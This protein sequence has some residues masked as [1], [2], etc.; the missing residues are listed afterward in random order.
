MG[1]KVISVPEAAVTGLGAGIKTVGVATVDAGKEGV[2]M[3][4]AASAS[5]SA[6]MSLSLPVLVPV[7]MSLS[8][9]ASGSVPCGFYSTELSAVVT[10]GAVSLPASI[11][12]KLSQ[13]RGDKEKDKDKEKEREKL[14]S[15]SR[16]RFINF[17]SRND[18]SK[19]CPR[20][21][22]EITLTATLTLTPPL[23]LVLLFAANLDR[24][25][26]MSRR[27]AEDGSH[28]QRRTSG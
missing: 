16:N 13:M 17:F 6:P 28:S 14:A 8:A 7:T 24:P 3:M 12:K 25:P 2:G 23:V 22:T 10:E 9:S 4:L 18:D 1:H 5:A 20:P 21:E 26:R 11:G 15:S 19:V 27:R